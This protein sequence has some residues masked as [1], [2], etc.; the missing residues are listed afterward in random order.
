[1]IELALNIIATGVIIFAAL[2]IISL[3]LQGS[4]YLFMFILIFFDRNRK[5]E[6]NIEDGWKTVERFEK[7]KREAGGV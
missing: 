6:R 1:M 3:V 4:F 2:F 7:A 5:D